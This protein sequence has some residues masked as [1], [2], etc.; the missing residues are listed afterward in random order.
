MPKSFCEE[1]YTSMLIDMN[2]IG[3]CYRSRYGTTTE[4]VQEMVKTAREAGVSIDAV[5]LKEGSLPD[6]IEDYD[7]IAIGS[8]IQA[9]RWAKEPLKFIEENTSLLATK[10]V[11]IFVVCGDAG[12]PAKCDEAQ[13][14]YLDNIAA[15]YP[16]IKP[17]STGLFGGMFDFKKY[18]FV[19]RRMVKSIVK[20]SMNEGEEVPDVMDFRDWDQIREWIIEL[21]TI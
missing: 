19:V 3:I 16:E 4:V 8:G 2:R 6:P 18:N 13:T 21:T 20:K 7:L 17:V 12:D 10:K 9:G 15:Q 1:E 14:M 5:D 11:A